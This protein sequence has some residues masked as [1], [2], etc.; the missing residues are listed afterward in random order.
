M[1]FDHYTCNVNLRAEYGY[2]SLNKD[3]MI[4][5]IVTNDDLVGSSWS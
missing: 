2:A 5:C 4:K 3:V 1:S